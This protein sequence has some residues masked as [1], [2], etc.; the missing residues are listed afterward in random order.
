MKIVK[1]PG[2]AYAAVLSGQMV[3]VDNTMFFS[4]LEFLVHSYVIAKA[5]SRIKMDYSRNYDEVR[6]KSKLIREFKGDNLRMEF[7]EYFI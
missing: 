5:N 3:K 7:P 4:T 1:T 6:D 2:L